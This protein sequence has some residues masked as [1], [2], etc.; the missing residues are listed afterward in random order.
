[1]TEYATPQR[2]ACSVLLPLA[3]ERRA[4]RCLVSL[5]N[6][7]TC[8]KLQGTLLSTCCTTDAYVLSLCCAGTS[9]C[10]PM[11]RCMSTSTRPACSRWAMRWPSTRRCLRPSHPCSLWKWRRPPA[12]CTCCHSPRAAQEQWRRSTSLS[13]HRLGLQ[14][15]PA[16]SCQ[17]RVACCRCKGLWRLP[18]RSRWRLGEL[19]LTGCRSGGLLGGD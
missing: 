11:S 17:A 13:R 2:C 5:V 16:A 12:R 3:I 4:S 7:G 10:S 18:C 8:P 14:L 6:K 19:S 15:Q 9:S 1:M